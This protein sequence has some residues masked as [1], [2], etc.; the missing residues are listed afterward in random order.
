MKIIHLSDLH[1]RKSES[2]KTKSLVEHILNHYSEEKEKPLIII[3]GD[4]V[5]SPKSERMEGCFNHLNLLKDAGHDILICPG[6]HDVKNTRVINLLLKK[7]NVHG[8]TYSSKAPIEFNNVFSP[9]LP[10]KS[11]DLPDGQND[12]LHFPRINKYGNYYF[13]GLNSNNKEDYPTGTI[14]TEQ[15]EQ[16]Q[17]Q[18][19]RI[20]SESS[21]NKIIVYLHHNIFWFDPGIIK[22]KIDGNWLRLTDRYDLRHI[23]KDQVDAVMFGHFHTNLDYSKRAE[24]LGIPL[25]NLAGNCTLN[26]GGHINWYELDLENKTVSPYKKAI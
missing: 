8:A 5:E 22:T 24:K 1:Y 12:L 18:I 17:S 10:K 13:I 20:K 23:L 15:L 21:D 25:I 19:K 16:L 6:N 7:Y 14:G 4:L 11:W 9:L 3:T 26:S 2:K